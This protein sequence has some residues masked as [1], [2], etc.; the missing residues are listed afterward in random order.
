MLT[1]IEENVGKWW[2]P[3]GDIIEENVVLITWVKCDRSEKDNIF[4]NLIR[5]EKLNTHLCLI[6]NNMKFISKFFIWELN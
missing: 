3:G 4:V 5:E 2:W 1:Y 6:K